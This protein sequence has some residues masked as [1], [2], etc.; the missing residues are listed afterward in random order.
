[1]LLNMIQNDANGLSNAKHRIHLNADSNLNITG[2]QEELLSAFSNLV[3]NAIRYTP[4]GGDIHI[5]WGLQHNEAIF[6]VRDTGIGIAQ[7][8]IDRLTERFYRVDRGRSRDTFA[9]AHEA[10]FRLAFGDVYGDRELFTAGKGSDVAKQLGRYCI[11]RVWRDAGA[12][13]F[14]V[15]IAEHG[16]GALQSGKRFLSLGWIGAKD[17][18]V[19]DTAHAHLVHRV[20]RLP[21]FGRVSVGGDAVRQRFDE[22]KAR[23]IEERMGVEAVASRERECAQPVAKIEPFEK[24]AHR[25]E[26][27]MRVRVDQPR[28][29]D[30]VAECDDMRG[31]ECVAEVCGT[32]DG[33]D[34]RV[35][36]KDDAFVNRRR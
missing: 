35:F 23:R 4:E 33:G 2:S 14:R 5:D 21:R 25:G 12:H 28:D 36:D 6:S 9:I 15:V 22:S 17:F 8:H 20:K 13:E 19:A 10:R 32:T 18:D 11:W 7:H 1:M 34:A 30:R 24:A 16:R 29:Q 26:F 3:S 27:E 31:G